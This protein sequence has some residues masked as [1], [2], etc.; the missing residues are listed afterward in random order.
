MSCAGARSAFGAGVVSR[1]V[2]VRFQDEARVGQK[3]MT[4]R[5]WAWRGARPRVVRAH[6][7]GYR[8]LF[9]A[10]VR[11][12]RQGGGPG[13]GAGGHGGDDRAS[14]G[15]RRGRRAGQYRRRRAGPGGMAPEAAPSLRPPISCCWNCRPIA[16][17]PDP[18]ETV[19]QYPKSNRL[20]NRVFADAVAAACRKA[21]D[22]FAAMPDRIAF[23]MR[24][25]WANLPTL[26]QVNPNG[27]L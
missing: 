4:P 21:W 22:R 20:A 2:E 17:Q 16:P 6:R 15:H 3:G 12:A 14:G 13:V 18:L 1:P 19:L 9:G 11:G 24:R 23:I 26:A 5:L 25:E 7:Y 27:W 8:Y 10:A